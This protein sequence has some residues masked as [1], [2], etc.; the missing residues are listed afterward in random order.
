MQTRHFLL[1]FLVLIKKL[2]YSETNTLAWC[3]HK[4]YYNVTVTNRGCTHYNDFIHL[5]SWM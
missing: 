2:K 5:Y 4:S 1:V 3:R